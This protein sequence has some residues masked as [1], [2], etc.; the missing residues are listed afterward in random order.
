MCCGEPGNGAV[1]QKNQKPYPSNDDIW[2]HLSTLYFFFL[3]YKHN[4]FLLGIM[5]IEI[6]FYFSSLLYIFH[7]RLSRYFPGSLKII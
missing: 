6:L 2:E 5:K 7:S 3:Y 4:K 1:L